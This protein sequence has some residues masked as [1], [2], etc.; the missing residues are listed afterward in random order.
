V[1][2]SVARTGINPKEHNP[3]SPAALAVSIQKIHALVMSCRLEKIKGGNGND[4]PDSGL[5]LRANQ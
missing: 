3:S 2:L 5:N 1:I 4:F